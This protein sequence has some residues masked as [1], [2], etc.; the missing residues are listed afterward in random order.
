MNQ[1][2]NPV[3]GAKIEDLTG[4]RF[5]RLTV[6]GIDKDSKPKAVRWVCKCDCGTVK[7]VRAQSLRR[8]DTKSCGCLHRELLKESMKGNKYGLKKDKRNGTRLYQVYRSMKSRC[9]N[10]HSTSYRWYG[11]RG[12][13][14]CA[15]WRTNYDAFKE[16]AYANGY[17]DKAPRGECTID[18]IDPNGNY[19]PENCRWANAM[20]QT[21][22]RRTA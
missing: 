8:G 14:M 11:A 19:C 16:W 12:I 21:H 6:L 4:R 22:N 7:S 13:G 20:E 9:Y 10:P 1:I 5:G 18:R 2:I 15:E 3:T 17:D